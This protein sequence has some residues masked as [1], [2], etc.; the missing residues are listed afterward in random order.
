M[1]VSSYIYMIRFGYIKNGL[2]WHIFLRWHFHKLDKSLN[3]VMQLRSN[4]I[5][6]LSENMWSILTSNNT[7]WGESKMQTKAIKM[8]T[9]HAT[10]LYARHVLNITYVLWERMVQYLTIKWRMIARCSRNSRSIV[11]SYKSLLHLYYDELCLQSVLFYGWNLHN[12][13]I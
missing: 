4:C 13:T 10:T 11:T 12:K 7:V 2:F 6:F 1:Y 8:T 3:L 9:K 5:G